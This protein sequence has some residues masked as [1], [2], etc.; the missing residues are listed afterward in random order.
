[1]GPTARVLLKVENKSYL[2]D[3]SDNKISNF[4]VISRPDCTNADEFVNPFDGP[5]HGGYH[6]FLIEKCPMTTVLGLNF[7]T[8]LV[9]RTYGEE[10][11][12]CKQKTM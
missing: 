6:G 4:G 8:T 10:R 3:A 12:P 9:A 1:M 5:S 7:N 2:G 11:T